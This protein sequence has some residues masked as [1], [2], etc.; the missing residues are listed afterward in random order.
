MAFPYLTPLGPEILRA[1]GIPRDFRYAIA[2]RV[3]FHEIDALGHV[4]N[5]RYFSWFE[6]FRLPYLRDY[7]ITD[8]GPDSPRLVLAATEAEFRAE[9]FEGEDY[10]LAGRTAWYGTSSFGMDYAV[11]APGLRVRGSATIALRQRDGSGKWPLAPEN[12]RTFEDRDGA[13]PRA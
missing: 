13:R 9:M 4:N 6:A 11:F 2:D 7:G 3:R 8:Y 12:I 5:A 10:I 1:H